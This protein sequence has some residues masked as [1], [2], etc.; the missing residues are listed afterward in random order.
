MEYYNYLDVRFAGSNKSYAFLDELPCKVQ[1]GDVIVF[2]NL[3]KGTD[4]FGFVAGT[5]QF[6]KGLP[7]QS[8]PYPPEKTVRITGILSQEEA[9]QWKLANGF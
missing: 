5:R 9:L 7:M 2:A 8:Y 1:I 6:L 3:T 4:R